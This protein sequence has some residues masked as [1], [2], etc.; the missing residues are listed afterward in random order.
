MVIDKGATEDL[1]NG[2]E[3]NNKRVILA[4]LSE[5]SV[6]SGAVSNRGNPFGVIIG[7]DTP[8]RRPSRRVLERMV[9]ME[10]CILTMFVTRGVYIG[11]HSLRP[12]DNSS[13]T[14]LPVCSSI[15]SSNT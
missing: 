10:R 7:N 11:V 14:D 6:P 15:D 9:M 2:E 5:G 12:L 4:G 1:V 8:E 3:T 13:F